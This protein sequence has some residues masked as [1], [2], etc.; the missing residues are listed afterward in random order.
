MIGF[1]HRVGMPGGERHGNGRYL[2]LPSK[3]DLRD[4]V[5][6]MSRLLTGAPLNARPKLILLH[7]LTQQ[8]H[9]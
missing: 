2:I 7:L 4:D 1:Y 5:M 6:A 3:R 8:G 9:D